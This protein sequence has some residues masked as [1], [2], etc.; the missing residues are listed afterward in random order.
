VVGIGGTVGAIGCMLIAEIVGPVLQWTNSY[1]ILFFIAGS[2]YL[3]ALL[4]IHT[5]SPRLDPAV[6]GQG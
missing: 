5:V 6:I 1:M 2:A 4:L 3:I